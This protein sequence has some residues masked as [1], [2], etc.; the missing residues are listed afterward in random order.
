MVET[1]KPA[2]KNASA[3]RTAARRA[4]A[5]RKPLGDQ[6]VSVMIAAMGGEGGGVL[7]SWLVNAARKANLPVQATSVPGVAQRTGA[8][9][10]YVEIVPKPYAKTKPIEPILD[11]Y[12]GPGDIDMMVATELMEVGRALEKGFI[13][14]KRTTLIGSTHRVYTLAEKMAVGDGRYDG[15]KIME[16]AKQMAKRHILFDIERAAQ[17]AGTIVNSVLL[18]AIAGSG[19]LP[20]GSKVFKDGIREEGK[21]VE[22]NLAGFD[23][24]Y[25][26]ATGDVVEL[27]TRQA[28]PKAVPVAPNDAAGKLKRRVEQDF[29]SETHA[30]VLEACGRCLDYQDADYALQYLDRLDTIR[31]IDEGRGDGDFKITNEAARH[32]GLRMTFEDIMR[33]AQLKTRKSR[34]ERLRRDV[35]AGQDHLVRTTEHFKPGPYE[36]ASIMPKSIGMRIVDWADRKPKS[37]RR[38]HFGMHIRSDTIWG[39]TRMRLLAGMRR[40]RRRGFRY[41]EE[42]EQI[43]EWL[44]MVRRAAEVSKPMALETVECAR[45]IKGYSDTHKR[46]VSNFHRIANIVV[47]PALAAGVDVA[48]DIAQ[49]KAAALADPEGSSLAETLS[50]MKAKFDGCD[51]TLQAT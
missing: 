47:K 3:T 18:G 23:I 22:S 12:P 7:T 20:I 50:A 16:A 44:N 11:L 36:F 35:Q 10:Y 46:G 24:G 45:L 8:T 6:P 33:V 37:A 39:F 9:T 4:A 27:Q 1:S 5:R 30:V 13:S 43:E 49:A 25:A 2:A 15:D 41:F 40:F 14:P 17:D 32:L 51:D 29:P 19:V 48:G 38:W 26:Y 28:I 34:F 42:Q 21:A 31:K